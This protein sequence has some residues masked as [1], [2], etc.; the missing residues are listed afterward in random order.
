[1]TITVS[2]TKDVTDLSV[3]D[4]ETSLTITPSTIELGVVNVAFSQASSADAI[5]S[6]ATGHITA[7]NVQAA[8]DEI[9]ADPQF[10]T[11]LK[12]KLDNIEAEA[13]NLSAGENVNIA[14]GAI[15][16]DVLGAISAGNNITISA[17]GE[18]SASAVS[19]TDVYTAANETEHLALDPTPNQGDVVIRTDENKTYIH[20]GGTTGTMADY[21]E[22]AQS[23]GVNSVNG[24]TGV[25]S[26][27]KTDLDDY[28]ANEYIDW[29]TAQASN[30]HPSNITADTYYAGDNI[31]FTTVEG[32]QYINAPEPARVDATSDSL[33][34][35]TFQQADNIL[36]TFEVDHDYLLGQDNTGLSFSSPH[37]DPT[38]D[39]TISIE[40]INQN[41]FFGGGGLI[42]YSTKSSGTVPILVINENTFQL[43]PN[44]AN[45]TLAETISLGSNTFCTTE[46]SG[47][48]KIKLSDKSWTTTADAGTSDKGL[49][50]TEF[51]ANAVAASGGSDIPLGSG[52]E[53]FVTQ[54]ENGIFRNRDLDV[55]N[56]F[57][58]VSNDVQLRLK[59]EQIDIDAGDATTI[60]AGQAINLTADANGNLT[61]S[62]NPDGLPAQSAGTDGYVLTSDGA[63]AN[64]V[65]LSVASLPTQTS[66]AG[67][68]LKTDGT[69]ASWD[70]VD[71]LPSRA[72]NDGKFL[73]TLNEVL[74][75]QD[76]DAFPEQSA[77]TDGK[78][79]SS[80]GV[81]ESWQ[82]P[83]STIP[84]QSTHTGKFLTTD[85]SQLS[86]STINTAGQTGDISFSQ[87]TLTSSGDTVTVDDDLTTTGT[88]DAQQLD[89]T[90]AGQPQI[91]SASTFNIAAP[92][93]LYINGNLLT[94]TDVGQGYLGATTVE[95]TASTGLGLPNT[96]TGL[97]TTYTD[98]ANGNYVEISFSGDWNKTTDVFIEASWNEKNS[99][100]KTDINVVDHPTIADRWQVHFTNAGA[101]DPNYSPIGLMRITIYEA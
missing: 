80:N 45:M 19:L 84:S 3:T 53:K 99:S 101:S 40:G 14:S 54:D 25:V 73:T 100:Q 31:T 8:L 36:Y 50:T 81:T 63:D 21:T 78:F 41:Y 76:V 11:A 59:N 5:S 33:N 97:T 20:N 70:D 48:H 95:I 92:E 66:N 88:L 72:G 75:W 18:I 94:G 10:T 23:S 22:L 32:L 90:G 49:A 24:Y 83:D 64:W 47:D 57:T 35:N 79:L 1:M 2:V 13:K 98:D 93:G 9:G 17:T 51:V 15:N 6:D 65:D 56:I 87:S 68:F 77:S 82:L 46:T 39:A 71:V 16:A 29:T 34:I 86:W 55:Q 52:H 62:A 61:I 7:T 30:I 12:N 58:Q 27:G 42:F 96:L 43:S 38:K 44:I 69:N 37:D 26:L 85:G 60:T 74:S 28:S 67:K 91:T 4:T 89:V